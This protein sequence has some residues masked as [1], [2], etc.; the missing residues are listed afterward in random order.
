[1]N[2][3]YFHREARARR[4]FESWPWQKLVPDQSAIVADKRKGELH[5]RAARAQDGSFLFALVPP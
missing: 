4:L 1:V 5:V 2:I 3:E